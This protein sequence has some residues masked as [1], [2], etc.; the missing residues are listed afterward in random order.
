MS[1][2]SGSPVRLETIDERSPMRFHSRRGPTEKNR[3]GGARS[4]GSGSGGGDVVEANTRPLPRSMRV[5]AFEHLTFIPFS[6]GFSQTR[7]V[8]VVSPTQIRS[9]AMAEAE[10]EIRHQWLYAQS[11][12][13]TREKWVAVLHA[14]NNQRK[15]YSRWLDILPSQSE[16][17]NTPDTQHMKNVVTVLNQPNRSPIRIQTRSPSPM[18]AVEPTEGRRMAAVAVARE[19]DEGRGRE[20]RD[21]GRPPPAPIR[22]NTRLSPSPRPVRRDWRELALE[23]ADSIAEG[24]KHTVDHWTEWEQKLTESY[25]LRMKILKKE[26]M[27]PRPR[28][29]SANR[30]GGGG[31]EEEE[32][33]EEEKERERRRKR[34]KREE[35][36]MRRRRREIREDESPPKKRK[37]KSTT[38]TTSTSTTTTTAPHPSTPP[39]PPPVPPPPPP[40]QSPPTTS[41]VLRQMRRTTPTTPSPT[42]KN[43]KR[44]LSPANDAVH[45]TSADSPISPPTSRLNRSPRSAA[46]PPSSH[47]RCAQSPLHALAPGALPPPRAHASASS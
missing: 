35:K 4:G 13:G 47:D 1:C 6:R 3:R 46:S 15:S 11:A 8:V 40:P 30:E 45:K 36:E 41:A 42:K 5:D 12:N 26:S 24:D 25:F 37:E 27:A 17:F 2:G 23:L 14:K 32:E 7:N 44:L 10:V 28:K 43:K 9:D 38:S 22:R 18:Q 39:P 16:L 31:R 20:D 33:E 29:R 34:T 19:R 21:E